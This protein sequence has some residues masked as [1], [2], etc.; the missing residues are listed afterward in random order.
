MGKPRVDLKKELSH[1]YRPS[2]KEVTIVDVP[3]MRF[4]MVDGTGN[5]KTAPGF[6]DA[7]AA[8]YSVAYTLKFMLKK[9]DPAQDYVVMPLEG[10]WWTEDQG[11]L[12]AGSPDA[13]KWTLMIALPDS[14]TGE[15]V[16]EAAKE[17]MKKRDLPSLSRVRLETFHEGE[18]VQI[19]HVGPYSE[20]GPTIARLHEFIRENGLEPAGRHHEIY[21]GDPRRCA[22]DKLKTVVRQPVTRAKGESRS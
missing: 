17:A 3:P 14:V 16:D 2:S 15:L 22:P 4:L 12:A 8:L 1:L 10:L 9:S 6:Q 13:W 11:G 18:C 19:M 5:P 20:E 7:M 21:L